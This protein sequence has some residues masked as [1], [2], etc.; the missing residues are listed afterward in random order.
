MINN[1]KLYNTFLKIVYLHLLKIKNLVSHDKNYHFLYFFES[2]QVKSCL[3]YRSIIKFI[4][5]F[6]FPKFFIRF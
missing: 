2:K 5:S 3:I 6:S 4:I 1:I